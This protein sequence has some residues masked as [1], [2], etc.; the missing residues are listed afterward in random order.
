MSEGNQI[1]INEIFKGLFFFIKNA[2]INNV[3][4]RSWWEILCEI[5]IKSNEKLI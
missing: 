1:K 5:E 4:F 3:I 2:G